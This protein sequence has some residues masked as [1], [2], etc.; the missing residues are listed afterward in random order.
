MSD[1]HPITSP[2]SLTIDILSQHLLL[3]FKQIR[4]LDAGDF[5]DRAARAR[6][7]RAKCQSVKQSI[8]ALETSKVETQEGAKL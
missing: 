4:E 5:P 2:H 8:K 1:L 7:L 6:H 3:W